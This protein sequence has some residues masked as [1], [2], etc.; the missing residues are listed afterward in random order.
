[1]ENYFV[2]HCNDDGEISIERLNKETL[3]NRFIDPD[4]YGEN[5][6]FIKELT[7]SDP[8]IWNEEENFLIIKGKIIIPKFDKITFE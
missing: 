8:Q 2:I 3:T 6:G 1:M 5:V 4:Y 7:E